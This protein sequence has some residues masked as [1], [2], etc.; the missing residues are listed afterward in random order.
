MTSRK[1]SDKELS[2]TLTCY[3]KY[4]VWCN[5]AAEGVN[6]SGSNWI[7]S[8]W[9]GTSCTCSRRVQGVAE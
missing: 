7:G 9:S 1:L 8:N 3:T 6:H 2:S 5:W 4:K